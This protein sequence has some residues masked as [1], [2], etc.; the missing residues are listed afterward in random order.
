[1]YKLKLKHHFSAAHQLTHAYSSECNDYKHGHNFKILVEIKVEKLINNMVID[2][3][4][5]KEI[6]NKLDHKDLNNILTFEPTAENISKY[7]HDEIQK[8]R[9]DAKIK[10]TIWEA[11][12]ASII[13]TKK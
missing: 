6:I 11:D 5:I 10:I 1:M 8:E 12:G 7:L 4:K 9:E 2:F 3:K 13:Y